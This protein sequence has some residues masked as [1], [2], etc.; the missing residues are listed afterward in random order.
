MV[1][2]D[3]GSVSHEVNVTL[4]RVLNLTLDCTHC[5]IGLEFSHQLPINLERL[6][7]SL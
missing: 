5:K 6:R 7:L 2:Y 4:V 1:S 3:Q